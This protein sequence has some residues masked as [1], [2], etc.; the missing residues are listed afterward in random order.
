VNLATFQ[1]TD[2]RNKGAANTGNHHA[3]EGITNEG[4]AAHLNQM[5]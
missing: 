2:R 1:S 3:L 4:T 5:R